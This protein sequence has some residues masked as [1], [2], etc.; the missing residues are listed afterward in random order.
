M[1][2]Q[3]SKPQARIVQFADETKTLPD[4]SKMIYAENDD[5]IVLYHQPSFGV[6]MTYSYDRETGK[7]IVNG[8]EGTNID[9]RTMIKL[10][11][12]FIQNSKEDEFVTLN[13]FTK[14]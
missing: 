10:G 3:D 11:S 14:K 12:Y 13:V 1:T 8:K 9:K 7:I 5:K 6:T 2:K 4:G